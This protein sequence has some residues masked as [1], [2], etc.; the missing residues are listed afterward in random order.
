MGEGGVKQ[1]I[2]SIFLRNFFNFDFVEF[3]LPATR[4]SLISVEQSAYSPWIEEPCDLLQ[5]SFKDT[6]HI[7]HT[8]KAKSLNRWEFQYLAA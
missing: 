6:V 8:L 3:I 5:E 4:T 2:R 1:D 7:Q